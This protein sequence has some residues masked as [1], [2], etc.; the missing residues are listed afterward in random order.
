MT[1]VAVAKLNMRIQPSA[2]PPPQWSALRKSW[3]PSASTLLI[4]EP[5][6]SEPPPAVSRRVMPAISSVQES[7]RVQAV[8]TL[9][10][11]EQPKH[12]SFFRCGNSV[13]L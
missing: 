9:H 4:M 8:F 10:A 1:Q 7:P 6:Q 5:E 13:G 3:R 11:P 12:S 2:L